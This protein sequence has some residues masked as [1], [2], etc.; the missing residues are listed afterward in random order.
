VLID[1]P[2]ANQWRK[3]M[4]LGDKD[5]HITVGYQYNDV[6]SKVKDRSTLIIKKEEL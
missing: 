5:F 3:E 4:G 2:S 6:H 1:W